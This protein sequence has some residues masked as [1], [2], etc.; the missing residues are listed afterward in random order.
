MYIEIITYDDRQNETRG[1]AFHEVF[2]I[3]EK[4]VVLL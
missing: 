2:T 4:D 1:V 3:V